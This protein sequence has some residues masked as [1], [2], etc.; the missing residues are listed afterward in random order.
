M[1]FLLRHRCW[2][3]IH[4]GGN[5]SRGRE[6]FNIDADSRQS[7]SLTGLPQHADVVESSQAKLA[8]KLADI[9]D[10]D[11]SVEIND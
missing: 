8:R 7:T 11:L 4:Y 2:A 6:L 1:G 9:L 3:Y 10:N 5:A